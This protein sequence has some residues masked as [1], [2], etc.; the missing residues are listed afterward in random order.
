VLER[1]GLDGTRRPETLA[2]AE[3]VRLADAFDARGRPEE[4][5]ATR[6]T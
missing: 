4:P 1:A 5:A 6:R 3:L 2:I